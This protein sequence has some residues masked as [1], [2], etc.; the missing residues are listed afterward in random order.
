MAPHLL[1]T[2]S[3][4]P[5]S[6]GSENRN[7]SRRKSRRDYGIPLNKSRRGPL[8]PGAYGLTPQYERNISLFNLEE[9]PFYRALSFRGLRM[10]GYYLKIGGLREL[11]WRT[12]LYFRMSCAT[13]GRNSSRNPAL[14]LQLH[15]PSP[16]RKVPQSLLKTSFVGYYP[17]Y[18]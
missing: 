7:L 18:M 1:V 5:P 12:F 16:P 9:H 15:G 2:K 8:Q 3:S 10:S 17:N 4:S 6:G 13:K 11:A 14:R